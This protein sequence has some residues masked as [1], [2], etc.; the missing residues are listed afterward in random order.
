[1]GR[2][3]AVAG[4]AAGLGL[5]A[6]TDAPQGLELLGVGL[7]VVFTYASDLDHYRST[8]VRAL[9]PVGRALCTVLRGW[10]RWMGMPAHRG[11]THWAGYA[12]FLG[13]LVAAPVG[14][15]LDPYAGVLLGGYAALGVLV[16]M[17]CDLPTTRSLQYLLYVPQ[18]L[19]FRTGGPVERRIKTVLYVAAGFAFVYAIRT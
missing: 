10:S 9:G 18:C 6:V 4:L 1:M 11:A 19:R 2:T 16:G 17:L 5:A 8:A 14:Y 7:G 15:W 3:Q 12:V 13:L